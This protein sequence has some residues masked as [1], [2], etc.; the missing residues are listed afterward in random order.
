MKAKYLFLA[1]PVAAALAA[2]TPKEEAAPQVSRSIITLRGA[3]EG[4]VTRTE[5]KDA[6]K[7]VFWSAEDEISVISLTGQACKFTSTNS[8][9]ALSAEFTGAAPDGFAGGYGV[10]YPYREDNRILP[11][12]YV[13]G[14]SDYDYCVSAYIPP[15]QTAAEGTFAKGTFPSVGVSASN[16]F[17]MYSIASGI[18][19]TVQGS[20]VTSVEIYGV[21]EEPICGPVSAGVS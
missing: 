21:E 17:K 13:S 1:V 16:E 2:C 9:P 15:V 19:F 11:G 4:P 7:Q 14:Y 18:C 10:I 6:G 5:V 3:Y 8:E 12:S 20:N